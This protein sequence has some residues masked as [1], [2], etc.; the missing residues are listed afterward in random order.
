MSDLEFIRQV[1]N[2]KRLDDFTLE[3]ESPAEASFM[4]NTNF[5]T[6]LQIF[7]KCAGLRVEKSLAYTK[8]VSRDKSEIDRAVQR[9]QPLFGEPHSE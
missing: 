9:L 2:F 7:D 5:V 8:M 6:G 1:R 3:S 4:G